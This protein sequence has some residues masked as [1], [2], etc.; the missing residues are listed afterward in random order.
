VEK[1]EGVRKN[2]LKWEEKQ[3]Q[4]RLLGK[5]VNKKGETD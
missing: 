1:Q 3:I 2:E 5:Y 4:K